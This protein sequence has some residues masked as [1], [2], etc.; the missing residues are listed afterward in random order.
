[1]TFRNLLL[2]SSTA[3]FLASAGAQAQDDESTIRAIPDPEAD[4]PEAVTKQV[5]FPSQ[6]DERGATRSEAGRSGQRRDAGLATA[7]NA[8]VDGLPTAAEAAV[9]GLAQA[10]SKAAEAAQDALANAV[11]AAATSREEFGRSHAPE[12]PPDVELPDQVPDH[13]PGPPDDIPADL[14]SPAAGD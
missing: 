11:D 10:Q 2:L 5:P 14:P 12:D 9:D 13:V 4:L 6:A 3:L 7:R 8:G 1:M